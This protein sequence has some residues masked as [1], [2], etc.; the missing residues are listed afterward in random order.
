MMIRQATLI[1]IP[2]L[3]KIEGDSKEAVLAFALH[4]KTPSMQL[5]MSPG[6]KAY[7]MFE[8]LHPGD[9]ASAHLGGFLSGKCALDFMYGS[10]KLFMKNNPHVKYLILI[11]PKS[12]YRLRLLGSKLKGVTFVGE[13]GDDVI[14]T[15]KKRR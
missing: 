15:L 7:T 12:N 2:E 14:Y 5:Y 4:I 3:S 8:T 10:Y 13:V 9:K 6:D 1:D 11:F